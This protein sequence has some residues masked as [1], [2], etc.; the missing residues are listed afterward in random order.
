MRRQSGG[1]LRRLHTMIDSN[2]IW[3][4]TGYEIFA[5][6]G[7]SGL[8]IESLARKVG[9]SK[10]S[11][12]HHFADLELFMEEL[13]HYHIQQSYV[14]ADKEKNAKKINPDLISIL[15]E[16]KIDLLFNRQLRINRERKLFYETLNRSNQIAGNAFVM[17]WIKDLNLQ[18]SQKQLE[19]IFEL[20][21]ENFY[22]Q[23]NLNNLNHLWL[24]EYFANLKRVICNFAQQ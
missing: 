6:F 22:L 2:D 10:S 17:V 14:I 1:N 15:V 9:I 18:L 8:I 12:Y 16:H 7:V 4:K 21:L 11:F 5:Q 20:A 23:I 13:L 19:G 3:I 24:S